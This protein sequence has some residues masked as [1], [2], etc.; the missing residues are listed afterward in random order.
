MKP[1]RAPDRLFPVAVLLLV[2]TAAFMARRLWIFSTDDAYITLR[3]AE[4]WIRDGRLTWNM[5][6]N[7]PVEGYTSTLYLLLA[8]LALLGGVPPMLVWKLAG[9]AAL[10]GTCVLLVRWIAPRAGRWTALLAAVLYACYEGTIWW[11]VSGLETAVYVFLLLAALVL[12]DHSRQA[13]VTERRHRLLGAAGLAV[14]LCG[15]TR[16]EGPA[17]GILMG[18]F[19]VADGLA[20]RDPARAIAAR[21]LWLA[22]PFALPYAAFFALRYAYFGR[23]WPNTFYCKVAFA[24]NP[25]ALIAVFLKAG[26]L[27]LMVGLCGF[28]RAAHRGRL[29]M[30]YIFVFLNTALYY[31]VDPI[32]G[33][34]NRHLLASLAL[35]YAAMAHGLHA[36]LSRL[37]PRLCRGLIL[38]TVVLAAG[39][40]LAHL[41][42][43]ERDAKRYAARMEARARLADY[44]RGIPVTDYAFGDAGLV[45]SMTP[46]VPVFDYYGLNSREF[47]AP[48]IGRDIRKYAEW[49]LER[50]P[51]AIVLISRDSRQW[52][53]QNTRQADLYAVFNTQ[54]G[55]MDQQ[56]NYGAPGDTFQ[57]RVLL[58]ADRPNLAPP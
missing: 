10:A 23:L 37:Q 28:L 49:L 41:P 40:G 27:P 9:V 4:N 22:L 34:L 58:R 57:Y 44:L 25:W 19:L 12:F 3:Y 51:Q 21:A 18:M 13:T 15:L 42:N 45:P 17:V 8:A 20:R 32:V 52:L 54:G 7:P 50:K 26:A 47:V 14:F 6:D 38:A 11:A 46:G 36:V 24:E 16:P 39:A 53:P 55:Y 30:I 1:I 48:A 29:A 33:H 2:V 31:G 56:V 35:S 43:L 5:E